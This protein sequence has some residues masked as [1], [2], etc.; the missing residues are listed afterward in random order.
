MLSIVPFTS[1]VTVPVLG[2]GIKPFGPKTFAILLTTAIMSGV[3]MITSTSIFSC[4]AE[5]KSSPP[6]FFTPSDF[7]S[8][9]ALPYAKTAISTFFPKP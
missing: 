6:T 9:A 7:A 1:F 5:T 8:S 2:F 4:N 3:A